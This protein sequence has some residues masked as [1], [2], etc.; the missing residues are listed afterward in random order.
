[1]SM[2][3]HFL[4]RLI[5]VCTNLETSKMVKKFFFIF[6]NGQKKFFPP[7]QFSQKIFSTW[8]ILDLSTIVDNFLDLSTIVD[9]LYKLWISCG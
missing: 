6:Q 5:L 3:A 4:M 7:G 9:E 8:S 1:M 2:L